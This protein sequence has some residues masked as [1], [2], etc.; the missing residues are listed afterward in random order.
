[1]TDD[2]RAQIRRACAEADG[3]NFDSLEPHDYQ[4]H[5]DAVLAVVQPFVDDLAIAD[6]HIEDGN[7]ENDRTWARVRSAEA[8]RDRL[9]AR[10][11]ELE[12]RPATVTSHTYD[13]AP[14]PGGP[15]QAEAFG[16]TCGAAWEQHEMRN[17]SDAPEQGLAYSDEPSLD[18]NNY[19]PC[20]HASEFHG[21]EAGCVECRCPSTALIREIRRHGPD[22]PATLRP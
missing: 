22:S 8:E 14:D 6:R 9:R 21:P 10:V 11:A 17:D 4:R 5:A 18:L 20:G 12:Q 2:L 15:C 1:M 7:M 3:F 19:C 16:E 13:G